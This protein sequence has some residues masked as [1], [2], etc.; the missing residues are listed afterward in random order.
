[1]QAWFNHKLKICKHY[2]HAPPDIPL[3]DF[4]GEFVLVHQDVSLWNMILDA[5]GRV[6]LVNWAH[7]GA[8]PHAVRP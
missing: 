1:M 3:F 8:Y 6:W 2:K 7:A 4:Q 5:A